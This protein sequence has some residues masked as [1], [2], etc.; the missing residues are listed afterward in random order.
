MWLLRGRFRTSDFIVIVF[1]V[2]VAT[3]ATVLLL[4]HNDQLN[5][6]AHADSLLQDIR[7]HEDELYD[8]SLIH[9]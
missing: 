3:T 5:Q 1:A 9:I 7:R 6:S 8:L 4:R 2:V